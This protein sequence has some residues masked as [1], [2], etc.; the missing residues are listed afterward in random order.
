MVSGILCPDRRRT[1][2]AR[3]GKLWTR[4]QHTSVVRETAL[5]AA[6]F[7]EV[8]STFFQKFLH[9]VSQAKNQ[10]VQIQGETQYYTKKKTVYL[11][12]NILYFIIN[13]LS[14]LRL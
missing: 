10:T 6:V 7:A 12:T 5:P 4:K 9:K 13:D 1:L 11:N 8:F 2:T 3:T 14:T